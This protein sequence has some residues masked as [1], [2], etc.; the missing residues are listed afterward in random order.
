MNNTIKTLIKD[1]LFFCLIIFVCY[2]VT[3]HIAQRVVVEG[4]SMNPTFTDGSDLIMSRISYIEDDPQRG[5]IIVFPYNH[6]HV[7]FIKRV[8]GLP[9]ETIQIKDG[10][11][12]I[13]GELL[14]EDYILEPILEGYEGRATNPLLLGE[15]EYFVM[16]DNRNNSLDSRF[17]EVGNLKKEDLI[18]KVVFRV[19]PFD[20][21]GKIGE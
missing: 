19:T 20:T 18:G 8:I 9:G 3:Q 7:Y 17:D 11:V 21:F 10:A 12:Y 5:D 6:S 16:G 2:F 15:D 13:N 1:I 4:A 14:E